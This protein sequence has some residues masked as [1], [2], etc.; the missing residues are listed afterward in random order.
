MSISFFRYNNR[1]YRIDNIEWDRHPTDQFELQDG[2][3]TTVF[4]DYYE[5]N[6]RRT[7]QDVAQPLF[8]REK[9]DFYYSIR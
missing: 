1:T 7:V 5:S 2:K 8:V 6:Y 9:T 4:I 3:R